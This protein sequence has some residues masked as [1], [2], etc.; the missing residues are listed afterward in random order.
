MEKRSKVL[1]AKAER[2]GPHP[3]EA[4]EGGCGR[5]W[6]GGILEVHLWLL[7]L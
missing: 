3:P 2:Q 6:C 5:D 4:S 7:A 1:K